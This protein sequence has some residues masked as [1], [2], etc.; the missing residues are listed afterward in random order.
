MP[1]NTFVRTV[2]RAAAGPGGPLAWAV[3]L[4]F[5]ALLEA[6]LYARNPGE[7]AAA[8]LLNLG[9]TIPL[10]WSRT[11]PRSA[12]LVT[13]VA[14]LALIG[15]IARIT[16]SAVIAQLL[17]FFILAARGSL[18][19]PA[20]LTAPLVVNFVDPIGSTDRPPAVAL[21]ASAVAAQVLGYAHHQRRE[22]IAERDTSRQEVAETMRQRAAMEERARIA[23]EMH[24]VV[25]HHVSM[26]V[27]QADEAR[28][29][30]PGMPEQGQE[31]LEVIST[32]AREAMIEM[33]RLL[34]VLRDER[35]LVDREPQPGLARLD[36]LVEAA[37][38]AGGEVRLTVSGPV[39]PLPPGTD[40]TAYRIVQEALTNARRH[41]PGA[42]VEVDLRYG[43][44]SLR[45]RIRDHGPGMA[46]AAEGHGLLGMRERATA[47]GGRLRTGTAAS[48]G[49]V[50][51]A[52]LPLA[53]VEP[54]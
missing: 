17:M 33:R 1:V 52:V 9:A 19:V 16:V 7:R 44:D 54:P 51:E 24:D 27:V 36:Q 49:G 38:E 29:A 53:G 26:I 22:A 45:V 14:V 48:G 47:A 37:R 43:S 18:L 13:S 6:A 46:A 42:D 3:L 15:D 25:A 32:T 8:L 21:L 50:V 40:L 12:A 39:S 20:L 23:R 2:R 41:A 35:S 30:T 31:R 4:S 5:G 34:G 11:A 28:L 10:A